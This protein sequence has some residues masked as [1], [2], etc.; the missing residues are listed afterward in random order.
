M[1]VHFRC[2]QK[3]IF[4]NVGTTIVWDYI[5]ALVQWLVE[6]L[7]AVYFGY[8]IV[9]D[10]AILRQLGLP[11]AAR[12]QLEREVGVLE[13]DVHQ[14]QVYRRDRLQILIGSGPEEEEEEE[15]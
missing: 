12:R 7:E 4:A 8:V 11:W 9:F 1:Y 5:D 2:L 6:A 10:V 13:F 14:L 15:D 3:A